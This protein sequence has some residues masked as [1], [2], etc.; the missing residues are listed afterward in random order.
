MNQKWDLTHS[1]DGNQIPI[2]DVVQDLHDAMTQNPHLLLFSANG[3]YDMATPFFGTVYT[4]NHM[5][6]D[7]SL[8]GHITYGFYESGH[9]VYLNLTALAQFRSDLSRWYDA[10]LSH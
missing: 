9:M 6:L 8:R 10:A 3:Y 2:P 1:I 7:P 4:L 5:A